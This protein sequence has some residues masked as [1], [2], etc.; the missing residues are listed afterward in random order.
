MQN[1]SGEWNGTFRYPGDYFPE[2]PFVARIVEIA[3]QLSGT[4]IEPSV[5]AGE[6]TLTALIRGV[7]NGN[8]V[9][10]TKAYIGFRC[11]YET[12]VDYVGNLSGDGTAITGVWSLVEAD[13]TFEMYRD[14]ERKG[15][16]ET[17]AVSSVER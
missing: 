16:D 2:T 10:F 4:I 17:R 14:P 6:P 9:D 5:E 12:P 13:G 1:L 11:G 15:M 8:S 7:R 3:G